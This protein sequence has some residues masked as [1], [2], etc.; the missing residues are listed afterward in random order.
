MQAGTRPQQV[1]DREVRWFGVVMLAALSLVAAWLWVHAY[2]GGESAGVLPWVLVALGGAICLGA[3]A[4]PKQMR[5]VHGAWMFVGLVIGTV[6]NTVLLCLM[7]YA[8][9]TAIGLIQRCFRGDVLQRQLDPDA[10]TY[11]VERDPRPAKA[12]YRRQF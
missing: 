4:A 6:V 12:R 8:C 3:L 10:E 2:R 1:T 5:P 9:F 7:Y 11:W